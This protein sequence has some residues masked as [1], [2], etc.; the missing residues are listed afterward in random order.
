M[1]NAVGSGLPNPASYT[2]MG[3]GAVRDNVT[4]LV[5][6][7][8]LNTPAASTLNVTMPGTM[9]DNLNYCAALATSNYA[10][11]SNWRMPTRVEIAS[12]LNYTKTGSALTAPLTGT[13][14]YD[15]TFSLWYET[16]AGI[17]AS[18]F[19]WVYNL[20]SFSDSG[21]TSNAYAQTSTAS[22][23]CVSGG[24]TGEGLMQQAVE[25][26]NHY[27]ISTGEVT[28]NYTG[29]VWQQAFSAAVMPWSSAAGYCSGLGLNGHTWRVPSL[30]EMATLVDEALVGPAINPTAFVPK[31][32]SCGD[33]TW[34]WG[35]EAATNLAGSSWGIN[36][37]DGYT[38]V[39]DAAS[40]LMYTTAYVRCVR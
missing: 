21:L 8:A 35:A 29:L 2:D 6:Q 10:G 15:R 16:I 27:A 31:T 36:F 3:N 7:K 33:T 25:P 4:C 28:D 9:T 14:G 17:N 5:W 40:F 11:I 39:N 24:G 37:C 20:T 38:G 32:P 22:V 19:G 23:R 26:P 18:G 30:K 1:P 34:F 12:V 13:S